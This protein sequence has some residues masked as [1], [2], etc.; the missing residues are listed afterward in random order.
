VV[1]EV[2]LIDPTRLTRLTRR[3]LKEAFGAVAAVQ[4]GV[5]TRLGLSAR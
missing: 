3:P 4:R 2:D 1:D 5:A